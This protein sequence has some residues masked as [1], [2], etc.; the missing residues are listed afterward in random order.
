[1]KEGSYQFIHIDV[2]G[3][4]GSSQ[5]KTITK[6]SG[7]KVT[8]TTKS[9]CAKE[10]LSEQW[11]EDG[12]CPH[13]N[14][15][16]EP[17]LLYGIPP[18]DVLPL[19]DEWAD[20]AKDAQGRKLRKD[21]NCVIIGV[22]SLPRAMEDEFPQFAEDT[23]EWLKEKYG[24]RLKSVV[25]HNDESH[26]HL[27]FTVVPHIGERLDD[28]H[29][30]Y[31]ASKQAKIDGKKKGEQNLAYIG[32]MRAFQDE[33][34]KKVAMAHGLTRIGPARRRLTRA[35]WHA[36]KAQAAFFADAKAQHRSVRENAYKV[37]LKKAELKAQEI[38]S[39]AQK[40]ASAFGSKIGSW[41]A[42]ISGAWHK[43]SANAL[44][45]AE[46]L[47]VDAE[48][49]KKK[50]EKVKA[51]AKEWADRRVAEVANQ[52]TQEKTR[53]KNLIAELVWC[54]KSKHQIMVLA[55]RA[56]DAKMVSALLCHTNGLGSSL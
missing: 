10:I 32:A 24:D 42:G 8:T 37:G 23:L 13:I 16:G 19:I 29:E 50:S 12:A 3:R 56:T 52:L 44:A 31:K 43:P 48:A 15:P 5:S 45:T 46:K 25:V 26:P 17:I 11:R 22:A 28:I 4:E 54:L 21:A 53:N 1:M 36:E 27:H 33:F 6:K 9:R 20:Q 47:K 30:G 51:Q 38:I 55:A 18:L 2:Y 35:Q 41:L 14:N 7:V 49:E 40:Q 39:N 34:S